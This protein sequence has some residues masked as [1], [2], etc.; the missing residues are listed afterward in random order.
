MLVAREVW[1]HGLAG[2]LHFCLTI[3]VGSLLLAACGDPPSLA[4]EA[5]QTP[6]TPQPVLMPRAAAT[7]ATTRAAP[8]ESPAASGAPAFV[9]VAAGENHT[10]AL[11][12][13]GAVLCWGRNEDGQLDIP[14]GA[15]FQKITTGWRFSC[16]IQTDGRINCWGRNEHKQL[17]AP[18]GQFTDIDAGWDH[19]CALRGTV[20]T[21]WGWN[22]NARA[23]PPRDF[24]F[25]AVGAGAEH[26]C[27]LTTQGDLVCWGNNDN[28][29]AESRSGPFNVLAVGITHTC[30]LRSDGRAL[31]QGEDSAG[32]SDPPTTAFTHVSAAADHSCG[33]LPTGDVNCWGGNF[34]EPR[35]LSFAPPGKFQS[36][37]A[38]WNNT[39]GLDI[40]GYAL[41]W[42][43]SYRERPPPPY[44][45][46]LLD[47][48]LASYTFDEPT[49]VFPWPSGGLAVSDRSGSIIAYKSESDV[50]RVLDLSHKTD[51]DG[52][53][54]GFLSASVDPDFDHFPF[55]YV[56]Y[57]V[58]DSDEKGEAPARL[59]RFRI[60]DGRA[61]HEEELI[62]LNLPRPPR[63]PSGGH[64]GGAIRF[65]PDGM[66]YLGIGDFTCF[67]CPQSLDTLYGK[68]VRLDVRGASARRPYRTPSDNPLV[69][70]V[71]ARP[72]IWAYG[73][74]NPWRMAFDPQDGR[75]WVGDVGQ[76]NAEEVTMATSGANLG[77]PIVEGF[78][79]F[80]IDERT[81]DQYRISTVNPCNETEHLTPPILT[82]E[83]AENCAIVGGIVY[84]GTAIPWLSG[85][86]LFGDYCSGRVWALDG[87]AEFGW[88]M[89]EIADLDTPLSSFGT[90]ADGEVLVLTFGGPI[91]RLVEAEAGYA[92]SVTHVP[93]WTILTVPSDADSSRDSSSS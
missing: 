68:I 88:R 92:P 29:R 76:G 58:R 8:S 17:D 53:E 57:T 18:N 55:L 87:D 4:S 48:F 60:V 2:M 45:R 25:I 74:R 47:N 33:T 10:C 43:S 61:V 59:S 66:L 69:D 22:A 56:Y 7:E 13:D 37:S 84:R 24:D 51:H 35:G 65:G 64:Y 5:D 82:Y 73:V 91:L 63:S 21:C 77:W 41:C 11:Q 16:G 14:K 90:D 83:H 39:C 27:G 40:N 36:T 20:A 80:E 34:R 32:Q 38:G 6:T 49:E 15:R 67:E 28:R 42:A 72:E 50:H 78:N 75:L 54:E 9:Q 12:H 71:G 85:T 81:M 1:K 79:C 3:L 70:V 46:I 26:S 62:I 23:T 44:D 89:I 19:V 86:Y 52:I 30:V 31:C 93:S